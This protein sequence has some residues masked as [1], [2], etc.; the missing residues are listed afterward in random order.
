MFTGFICVVL[1]NLIALTFFFVILF[2]IILRTYFFL[3]EKNCILLF[4]TCSKKLKRD[5]SVSSP[6]LVASTS[7]RLETTSSESNEDLTSKV[8]NIEKQNASHSYSSFFLN[9]FPKVV[10]FW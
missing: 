9:H 3:N 1:E 7:R 2:V 6:Y 8:P 5:E 10:T 4:G